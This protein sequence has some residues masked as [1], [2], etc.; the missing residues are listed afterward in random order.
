MKPSSRSDSGALWRLGSSCRV[1][2]LLALLLTPATGFAMICKTQ[3]AGETVVRADLDSSVAIPASAPDG[4]I[5]WRSERMDLQV[6]CIKDGELSVQEEIFL[7]LNPDNLKIGQ[8]IRAG[9]TLTGVDHSQNSGRIST[10]QYLPACP[11]G[12]GDIVACPDARFNLAFSVFIQKFGPTPHSGIASDLLDYRVFQLDSGKG[13]DPLPDHSLSYRINNLSGLRFVACDAQL[14]VVPEAMDFGN[15]GI[16]QVAV[17]NVIERRAFSLVA[18]RTCDSPFSLGARFKPVSGSLSGSYL[19]PAANDSVGIRIL[20]ARDDSVLSYNEP[21]HLVDLLNDTQ[22][23]SVDF[24][25]EL[26][27]Q[28]NT[29]KTGPFEAEVMIDLFYK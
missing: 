23:A 21:F 29:P 13:L 14:Q 25:A 3:G 1:L 2:L 24:N 17:G 28:T 4:D 5:V 6:E 7:Y 19:I 22:A 16:Q 12:A 26:V 11:Q 9:L 10:G 27:W 15:I 8:G 20:N 18:R